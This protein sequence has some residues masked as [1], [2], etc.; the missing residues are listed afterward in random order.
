MF[1]SILAILGKIACYKTKAVLSTLPRQIF[2][3]HWPQ[4]SSSSI[5]SKKINLA[6]CWVTGLSSEHSVLKLCLSKPSSSF[7]LCQWKY[8]WNFFT[9]TQARSANKTPLGTQC[10]IEALVF[11][12]Q[13]A[14]YSLKTQ[15]DWLVWTAFHYVSVRFFICAS[16]VLQ[17]LPEVTGPARSVYAIPFLCVCVWDFKDWLTFMITVKLTTILYLLIFFH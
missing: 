14:P 3:K 13:M 9:I 2:F 15:P 12:Q 7:K 8:A 4:I 1:I 5:S 10:A 6:C 16:P 11:C 17:K